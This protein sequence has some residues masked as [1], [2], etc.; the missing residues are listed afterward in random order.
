M[1]TLDLPRRSFIKGLV[2]FVAAAPAVVKA[3]SLMPVKAL[4]SEFDLDNLLVKATER[5]SYG[6]VDSRL[7]AAFNETKEIWVSSIM[8][9]ISVGDT[10]SGSGFPEG[11][12]EIVKVSK[13]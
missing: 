9:K 8:G 13:L 1:G 11:T 10:I 4:P 5:Y 12:F 6:Y 3:S 7:L 2:S